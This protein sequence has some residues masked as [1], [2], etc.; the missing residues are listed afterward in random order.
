M[1]KLVFTS[2][3]LLLALTVEKALNKAGIKTLKDSDHHGHTM[4][5]VEQ[6]AYHTASYLLNKQP[7]YG[8]IFSTVSIS[9]IS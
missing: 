2:S 6:E 3:S 5:Y 8:E 9:N 7:R 1:T 4:I